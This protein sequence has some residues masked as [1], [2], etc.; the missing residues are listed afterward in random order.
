MHKNLTTHH[1]R[2]LRRHWQMRSH[3]REKSACNMFGRS[4]LTRSDFILTD[5]DTLFFLETNTGPGMTKES[6]CPKE[7][8]AAGMTFA[9][10]IDAQINAATKCATS[11]P[12][13]SGDTVVGGCC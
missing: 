13:T 7:A 5:D 8:A 6:L 11:S 1:C 9:E 4:G 2:A 12:R 3:V 10:L